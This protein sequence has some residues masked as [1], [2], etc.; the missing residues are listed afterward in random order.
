MSMLEGPLSEAAAKFPK[1]KIARRS[2]LSE[3]KKAV[4]AKFVAENADLADKVGLVSKLA[5]DFFLQLKP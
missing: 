2:A 1:D 4:A 3:A 5:D